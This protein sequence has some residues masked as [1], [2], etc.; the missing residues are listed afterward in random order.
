MSSR[1]AVTQ[2]AWTCA[3][4]HV[5][6]PYMPPQPDLVVCQL[7]AE[8][9]QSVGIT[10]HRGAGDTLV[11][12]IRNYS[13]CRACLCVSNMAELALGAFG[14]GIAAVQTAGGLRKLVTVFEDISHASDN[15]NYFHLETRNFINMLD[16]FCSTVPN[17]L[18]HIRKGQRRQR[19]GLYIQLDSQDV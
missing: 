14:A 13:Q 7:A 5:P 4:P 6:P 17:S 16:M 15:I 11:M 1:H 19:L 8:R 2:S 3:L 10:S 9:K 12:A 18:R